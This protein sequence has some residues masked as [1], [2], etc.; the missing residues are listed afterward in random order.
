MLLEKIN[1]YSSR[2][3]RGEE[4]PYVE[5]MPMEDGVRESMGKINQALQNSTLHERLVLTADLFELWENGWREER[6]QEFSEVFSTAAVAIHQCAGMYTLTPDGQ[7][8]VWYG[9]PQHIRRDHVDSMGRN[10]LLHVNASI[11]VTKLYLE[12]IL[13]V[14]SLRPFQ[15]KNGVQVYM[16]WT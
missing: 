1:E 10:C 9:F 3:K 5:L 12:A 7:F 2:E 14:K 6:K 15:L 8:R 11:R 4:S 16:R 13:K